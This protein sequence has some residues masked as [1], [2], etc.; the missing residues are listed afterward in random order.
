MKFFGILIVIAAVVLVLARFF[1]A[2]GETGP[3]EASRPRTL[4]AQLADLAECGVSLRADRT[5]DELLMSFPREEYEKTPTLLIVMLGSEVE[6]EPWG[7]HF[8]DNVW[9][10]DTEYIE[11]HGAYADIAQ[12]MRIL[13]GG[14]LPLEDIKD[15]VDLEEGVAWLEFTLDGETYHW[16]A[17]VNDDWVD[18]AILSR[19]AGLL[20]ERD[21]GVRFTYLDLG[22]QDCVLGAATPQQLEC[23]QA[24]CG[25]G[26]VW[27]E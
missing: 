12:H 21:Q 22:G 18:P 2:D 3:V 7:R 16:D 13:A 4:E 8:S 15:Y 19:L 14:A 10:F 24:K 27:L 25:V 20:V 23:L 1:R 9:H 5:A 17:T 6:A 11:D 26:F